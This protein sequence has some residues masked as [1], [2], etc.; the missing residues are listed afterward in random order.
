V[1]RSSQEDGKTGSFSFTSS[2]LP[3]FLVILL[4]AVAWGC[5]THQCD[6]STSK[7]D[8]SQKTASPV[9]GTWT[10][11]F[12]AEPRGWIS[13]GGNE[14]ITFEL[15]SGF[16]STATPGFTLSAYVSTGTDQSPEGGGQFVEAAGQLAEFQALTSHSFQVFN[17]SCATYYLR[18]VAP[19]TLPPAPVDAGAD[20]PHD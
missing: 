19:V 3:V 1:L 20:A 11:D 13:Y 7:A 2:R 9:N 5:S 12:S 14:T 17:D 6:A 15:P 16:P 18:V 4:S 10:W 8:D